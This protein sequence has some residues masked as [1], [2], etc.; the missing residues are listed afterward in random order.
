MTSLDNTID[1]LIKHQG[2][3]TPDQIKKVSQIGGNSGQMESFEKFAPTE[4]DALFTLVK[5]LQAKVVT[6]DGELLANSSTRDLASLTGSIT[7]LL[8][9]FASHQQKIN[10]AEEMALLKESVLA[11][12]MP[13]P[14]DAQQ[15]F[16]EVLESKA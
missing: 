3:L 10:D 5:T 2:L 9:A 4:L 8:R 13:L 6:G 7:S 1:Y 16:F 14:E 12:I 15:R 11:A